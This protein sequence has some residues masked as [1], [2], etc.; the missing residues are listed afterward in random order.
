MF[1][2][3][4]CKR[5]DGFLFCVGYDHLLVMI[6]AI[7]LPLYHFVSAMKSILCQLTVLEIEMAVKFDVV[8]VRSLVCLFVRLSVGNFAV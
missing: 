3:E 8:I 5:G 6:I 2:E 4:G 7:I 1:V